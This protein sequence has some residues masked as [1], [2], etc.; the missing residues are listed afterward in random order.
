MLNGEKFVGYA[1]G[2]GADGQ[3]REA[4]ERRRALGKDLSKTVDK[5]RETGLVRVLQRETGYE[6]GGT[7]TTLRKVISPRRAN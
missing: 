7:I 6:L 5:F 3:V 2:Q 1:T 4:G